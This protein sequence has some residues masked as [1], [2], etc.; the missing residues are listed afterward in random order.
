MHPGRH[1]NAFAPLVVMRLFAAIFITL[2]GLGLMFKSGSDAQML[3]GAAFAAVG[4]TF[5]LLLWLAARTGGT[6]GS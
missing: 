3:E 6:V 5:F 2:L 4:L 1:L